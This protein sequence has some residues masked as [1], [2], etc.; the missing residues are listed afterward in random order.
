MTYVSRYKTGHGPMTSDVEDLYAKQMA[1]QQALGKHV[2][3]KEQEAAVD[4]ASASP[5]GDALQGASLGSIAGPWGALAGGVIGLASGSIKDVGA[6]QKA[7]EGTLDALGN[8]FLDSANPAKLFSGGNTEKA[9]RLGSTLKG[10]LGGGSRRESTFDASPYNSDNLDFS[11][12]GEAPASQGI[13]GE[14]EGVGMGAEGGAGN[15]FQLDAPGELG[16]TPNYGSLDFSGGGGA[17]L[18][19]EKASPLTFD[20]WKI[21]P[22]R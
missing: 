14:L 21:A 18:T 10:Q 9:A 4:Q 1:G 7:G 13:G 19:T 16:S 6:R 3:Q 8:T 17:N 20:W 11:L 22:P 12:G 5:M 2:F 15:D